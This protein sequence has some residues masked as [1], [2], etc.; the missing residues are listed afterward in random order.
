V[1]QRKN[2]SKWLGSV[3]ECKSIDVMNKKRQIHKLTT[4]G[5][6]QIPQAGTNVSHFYFVPQSL[7]VDPF[8]CEQCGRILLRF[9]VSTTPH[10][11][12]RIGVPGFIGPTTS[13]R[14]DALRIP[15]T[16]RIGIQPKFDTL[17]PE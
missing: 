7:W 10:T 13:V 9:L 11:V 17:L 14:V 3:K 12:Y 1:H 6:C 2:S 15:A 8:H 5:E 16:G 4:G